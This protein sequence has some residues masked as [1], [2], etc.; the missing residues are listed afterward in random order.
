MGK[1]QLFGRV[2]G[3]SPGSGSENGSLR[4]SAKFVSEYD[5]LEDGGSK[6]SNGNGAARLSHEDDDEQLLGAVNGGDELTEEEAAMQDL[7]F[8]T[9][10]ELERKKRKKSLLV[11]NLVMFIQALQFST[12][13]SAIWP[14]LQEVGG[15]KAFL[16]FVVASYSL[17]Q[18]IGSPIFGWWATRTANWIPFMFCSVPVILGNFLYSLTGILPEGHA[19]EGWMLVSRLIT[20]IGGGIVAVS[21]SYTA[22]ATPVKDKRAALTALAAFQALG[23]VVGPCFAAVFTVIGCGFK[24]SGNWRIDYTTLPAWMGLGLGALNTYIVHRYF[25]EAKQVWS[26]RSEWSL[27][28]V[29]PQSLVL[30]GCTG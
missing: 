2:F 25:K 22:G 15:H 11:V 4:T 10:S 13:V 9:E 8:D 23:F 27:G 1:N 6:S 19:A 18:A 14:L 12:F 28:I 24:L 3:G 7:D 5:P 20:G 26:S 21:R 30:T 29:C 17:G 16:G